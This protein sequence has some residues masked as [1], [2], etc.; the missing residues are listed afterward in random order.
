MVWPCPWGWY[1]RCY[2]VHQQGGQVISLRFFHA[3]P[4]S[5]TG[6]VKSKTR[7]A[8]VWGVFTYLVLVLGLEDPAGTHI[9]SCVSLRARRG[10]AGLATALPVA[11][12]RPTAFEYALK[13]SLLH[14]L[15]DAGLEGLLA[16]GGLSEG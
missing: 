7:Q 14:A 10:A 4:V 12:Q 8:G 15:I 5:I 6:L 16:L 2:A 1:G 9:M 13:M 3:L 11:L